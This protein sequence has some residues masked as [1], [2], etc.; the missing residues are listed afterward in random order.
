MLVSRL[1]Y[2]PGPY[3]P[4]GG[5]F[6]ETPEVEARVDGVWVRVNAEVTPDYVAGPVVGDLPVYDFVIDPIATDGV[7]L[8]GAVG[9]DAHFTSVSELEVY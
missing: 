4:L 3:D 8:S 2:T 9:S 5:W 1:R 6:R 7:R